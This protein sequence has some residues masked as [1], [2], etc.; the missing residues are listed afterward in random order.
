MILLAV[1]VGCPVPKDGPGPTPGPTPPS[2]L[3]KIVDR[4]HRDYR[5]R[6]GQVGLNVS[7]D[8]KSGKITSGAQ[9]IEAFKAA[10]KTAR[11]DAFRPVEQEFQ[12]VLGNPKAWDPKVAE[13]MFLD[14]WE[15]SK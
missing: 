12:D 10:S 13:Q 9:A 7:R 5:D 3:T 14:I 4:A 1:C 15:G 6:I 8:I 2:G 11:E